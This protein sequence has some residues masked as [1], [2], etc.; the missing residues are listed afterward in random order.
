MFSA[1][2]PD[3]ARHKQ[4]QV[5]SVKVAVERRVACMMDEPL[6]DNVPL[7]ART[8]YLL[9]PVG[10]DLRL[11]DVLQKKTKN[12]IT[13]PPFAWCSRRPATW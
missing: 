7:A 8:Q 6:S 10:D 1:R 2:I 13:L 4:A 3:E 9:P 12:Q 11:G 5:E